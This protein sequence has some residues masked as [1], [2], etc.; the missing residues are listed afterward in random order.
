MCEHV[1]AMTSSG[2]SY[3]RFRRSLDNGNL[4]AARAAATDLN[5]VGLAE[6]LELTLLILAKEP[7]RFRA[8]ALRWHARYCGNTKASPEATAPSR[9][10]ADSPPMF[11][12]SS[13]G[14]HERVQ[15]SS[16]WGVI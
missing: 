12:V 14:K 9:K 3:S 6:A 10:R 16:I 1:F 11:R 7:T 4:L 15:L 2:G 8:A 5:H 13:S